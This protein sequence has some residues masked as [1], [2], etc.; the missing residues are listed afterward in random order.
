MGNT[1]CYGRLHSCTTVHPHACGEHQSRALGSTC[2]AGSSPRMWGTPSFN[3]SLFSLQRFIPTHVG[4]TVSGKRL[5]SAPSVHPHA[6]GE[7]EYH[8]YRGAFWAGSSPRMWGTLYQEALFHIHARFIPTH[9]GNTLPGRRSA[10][11]CSVHPHAC[12]EHEV[13]AGQ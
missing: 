7:H 11:P 2:Y 4:N 3:N 1:H 6:C 5:H 10:H 9:V 8:Y 13:R 12:G